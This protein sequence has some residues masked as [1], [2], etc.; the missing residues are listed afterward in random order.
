MFVLG[1]RS[2][3]IKTRNLSRFLVYILGHKPD[4]FGLV[5]DDEG[6]IAYKELLQAI[7][8]EEGWRYVRKSHINEVLIGRDREM[9]QVETDRIKAM[10]RRWEKD[11]GNTNVSLPVL[12]FI[13]VRKRGHPAAMEKGLKAPPA[14][15]LVLSS[16]RDMA[17]RI[18]LRR[19]PD[20]VILEILARQASGRGV[21]FYASGDLVLA[22]HISPEFIAGPPVP[23]EA[24]EKKKDRTVQKKKPTTKA[25]DPETGTFLL[26]SSRDPDPFR[27]AKGAKGKKPK[28][29]KEEVRKARRRRE[30]K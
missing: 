13:S 26:D 25:D 12:L 16:Q 20:P 1:R 9:F 15:S 30:K 28:G 14:R 18:G 19:G 29:W 8:E 22:D 5:P 27:R 11:A 6:F 23:K 21:V 4:E 17:L 10:E 7:H 2:H 3:E 24:L